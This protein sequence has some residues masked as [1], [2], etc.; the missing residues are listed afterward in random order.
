MPGVPAPPGVIIAN[1]SAHCPPPHFSLWSRYRLAVGVTGLHPRPSR[2][3]CRHHSRQESG[4][5][6]PE[7]SWR[8]PALALREDR[9]RR[10]L[11]VRDRAGTQAGVRFGPRPDR[12]CA[13][14]YD[15]HAGDRIE[16]VEH[17]DSVFNPPLSLYLH[18][19]FWKDPGRH[20]T[21]LDSTWPKPYNDPCPRGMFG[22]VVGVQRWG[23]RTEAGLRSELDRFPSPVCT[24]V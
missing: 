10:E 16:A 8:D 19:D 24:R 21:R 2:C 17:S 6:V 5:R 13:W 12:R 14:D 9:Y 7:P 22:F 20:F 3:G 4:P 18:P 11:P 15:R 1:G 23:Y